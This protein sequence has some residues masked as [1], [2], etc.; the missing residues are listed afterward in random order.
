MIKKREA[1]S[2]YSYVLH[3]KFLV[4]LIYDIFLKFIKLTFK[5]A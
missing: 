4:L 5:F 3:F 2:E 1:T